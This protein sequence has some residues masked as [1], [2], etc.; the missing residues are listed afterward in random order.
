MR[1]ALPALVGVVVLLLLGSAQARPLE[2]DPIVGFWNLSGGVVQVSGSGASFTG[3]IVKATVFSECPHPVGELIWRIAK[4]GTGYTGSHTWFAS[5]APEC[6][7]GGA[8]DQG[9]STW[10]I[11]EGGTSLQ[12]H[13]CTTNPRNGSDTRCN[14]LTRAKPVA[15]AWP[16]LPDALVPIGSVSNGCGGG[17]AGNDPKYGDDSDFVNSE[18]PFADLGSWRRGKKYHVNFREACKLHDAGY[19]HAKVRDALHGGVIVDFFSWTKA[20]IDDKFLKDMILICDRQVSEPGADVAR[21][22]CKQ[23]GGFHLVSGA[24]S[25]YNVVAATTYTGY[26]GIGFY[27]EAPKVAGTWTLPTTGGM[28]PWSVRQAG[29]LITATWTGGTERSDLRGEFRGTLISH[30]ADSSIEGFYAITSNGT[31]KTPR[32]MKLFWNPKKP[33]ELRVSTGFTLTR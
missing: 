3:R 32:A 25:R 13:F 5:S 8:A 30:D 19:S 21:R 11:A 7:L 23:N 27:Q 18:I 2:A 24:K 12:L 6:K 22:N 10:S 1:R 28:S 15:P 17:P 9:T 33:N 26:V 31:T 16:E 20:Q 14:D 4:A 29:R